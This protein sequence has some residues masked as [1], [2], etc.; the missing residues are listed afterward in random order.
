MGRKTLTK[1]N[2]N[3]SY[4][5]F[6]FWERNLAFDCTSSF[7]LLFGYF[8]YYEDNMIDSMYV[9]DQ[10]KYCSLEHCPTDPSH[11][12][13][14]WLKSTFK[15]RVANTTKSLWILFCGPESYLFAT[16]RQIDL[17]NVQ[18]EGFQYCLIVLH[19]LLRTRAI[20]YYCMYYVPEDFQFT[21]I[22]AKCMCLILSSSVG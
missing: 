18:D 10:Y 2:C 16:W 4:F 17:Q 22:N 11:T 3:F 7:S 15:M 8:Y 6:W 1:H 20:L 21:A 19:F 12:L 9:W 14:N 13:S 5:S